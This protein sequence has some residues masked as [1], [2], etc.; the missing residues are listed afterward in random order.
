MQVEYGIK[1][2]AVKERQTRQ[3]DLRQAA[4]QLQNAR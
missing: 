2:C 3:A 4:T 1:L